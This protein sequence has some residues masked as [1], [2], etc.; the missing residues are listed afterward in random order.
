MN[1]F[2]QA[3]QNY[4]EVEPHNAFYTALG[5]EFYFAEALG[6]S[7]IYAVYF[8]MPGTPEDTWSNIID[9]VSFQINCYADTPLLAGDLLEKCRDLF[10]GAKLSVSGYQDIYLQTQMFTPPWRDGDRWAASVEFQGFLIK[11]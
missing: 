4:F 7:S 2:F 5:G 10:N 1:G 9:D 11:E 8:G 6:N 3:I